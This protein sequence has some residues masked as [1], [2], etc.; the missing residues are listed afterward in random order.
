MENR[1]LKV[2]EKIDFN[3]INEIRLKKGKA[4][5]NRV[6][7]SLLAGIVLVVIIILTLWSTVFWINPTKVLVGTIFIG[8]VF[9]CILVA[10][11][12]RKIDKD[13]KKSIKE[14]ITDK[15]IC[16]LGYELRYVLDANLSKNDFKKSKLIDVAY[17]S[18]KSEDLFHGKIGDLDFQFS[19]ISI[20]PN[21]KGKAPFK[22]LYFCFDFQIQEEFILDVVEPNLNLLDNVNSTPGLRGNTQKFDCPQFNEFYSIFTN[23]IVLAGSLLSEQFILNFKKNYIDSE[24]ILFFSVRE[25]KLHIALYN[26]N[27]YFKIDYNTEIE[28]QIS[29]QIN[30]IQ[31]VYCSSNELRLFFEPYLIALSSLRFSGTISSEENLVN[32][33]TRTFSATLS[34]IVGIISLLLF[35]LPIVSVLLGIVAVIFGVKGQKNHNGGAASNKGMGVAGIVIG[36]LVIIIGSIISVMA[37]TIV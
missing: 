34:L 16:A 28:K 10:L 1:F 35:W 24:Q 23:D 18:F 32:E 7:L 9:T 8:V 3:L 25:G 20:E 13:Y 19:E 5:F 11:L 2:Q 26:E 27:D 30:D 37:L 14:H 4:V 33:P 36:G 22:G 31:F 15:V 6:G 21:Y 12:T 17:S 29:I